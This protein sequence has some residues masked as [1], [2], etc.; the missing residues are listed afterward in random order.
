MCCTAGF[1]LLPLIGVVA[2]A[3]T[4]PGAR[5]MADWQVNRRTC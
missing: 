1:A 2:V 4:I 5:T 3:P